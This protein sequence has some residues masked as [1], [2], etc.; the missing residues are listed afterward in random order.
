MKSE[1]ANELTKK[2]FDN[3]KK[4]GF[5]DSDVINYLKNFNK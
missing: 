3:M 2:Y 5:D 4:I 1:Y